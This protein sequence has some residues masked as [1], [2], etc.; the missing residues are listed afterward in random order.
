MALSQRVFCNPDRSVP[1]DI[2]AREKRFHQVTLL[3]SGSIQ[4]NHHL[5]RQQFLKLPVDLKQKWHNSLPNIS[6]PEIESWLDL[7]LFDAPNSAMS[8]RQKLIANLN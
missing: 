7:Y 1:P 2:I 8:I 5:D 3:L 4:L 6:Y